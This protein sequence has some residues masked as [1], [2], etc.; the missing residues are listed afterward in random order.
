[1]LSQGPLA[2]ET[3]S[4][5]APPSSI[6]EF[7][8]TVNLNLKNHLIWKITPAVLFLLLLLLFR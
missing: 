1:M 8:L 7:Y 4:L 5:P 6:W 2:T 3:M